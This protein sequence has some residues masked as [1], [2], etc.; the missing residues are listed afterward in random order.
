MKN[1]TRNVYRSEA[2]A[3]VN[4]FFEIFRRRQ[5]GYHDVC[6]L[7]CPISIYDSLIFEPLDSPEM[8]FDCQCADICKPIGNIPVN[9]E[10]TV[11]R[12]IQ[13]IRERYGI[14]T[15][16][17]VRLVKR[18]P[19]QAGMGG[20]SSD[21]ATVIQLANRAWNLRLSQQE[22]LE[23]G[24]EL[25][26]DVPLFFING[27]SIGYGRGEMVKSIP[28]SQTL[29]F[30]VVKPNEGISTAEA[31][32]GCTQSVTSDEHKRSPDELI[33]GLS[34]GNW[35]R[36]VDG[37]YNRLERTAERLCPTIRKIREIFK[38]LDCGVHQLTG[39]G[40]AYF[41]LCRHKKH[42]E[43]LAAQLRRLT[44]CSVFTA[45]SITKL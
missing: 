25:G 6:S 17:K 26:S 9:G 3:K 35:T 33:A 10:N 5:D 30:V 23:L 41:G 36:I 45:Q 19:S 21:A 14:S 28:M 44:D 13:K 24:A 8:E 20:G 16:C 1:T 11:V 12:A 15:G 4:L 40:T 7:C 43:H 31:F 38:N 27:A 37:L 2:P 32:R 34:Q 29:Y 22:M 39:S 42:A 18:I